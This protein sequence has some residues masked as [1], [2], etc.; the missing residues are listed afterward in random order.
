MGVLPD[1][2]TLDAPDYLASLQ[3]S[4]S[5]YLLIDFFVTAKTPQQI[6]ATK[7][8]GVLPLLLFF[9]G[10]ETVRGLDIHY[11]ALKPDGTTEQL[12]AAAGKGLAGRGIPGV[13]LRSRALVCG[14]STPS[15][16][17]R[18][19]GSMTPIA[20]EGSGWDARTPRG[21]TRIPSPSRV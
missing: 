4:L 13:H 20:A 7:L 6:G 15:S 14:K 17:I 11:V 19:T 9:L 2:A 8:T 1:F 3:R 16:P 18:A 5:D 21:A 10:R 12:P